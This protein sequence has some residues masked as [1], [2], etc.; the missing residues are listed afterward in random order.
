MD[1]HGL[2]FHQGVTNYGK[3]FPLNKKYSTSGN[4]IALRNDILL[5]VRAPV[6]RINIANTKMILGRGLCSIRSKSNHQTFLYEQLKRIFQ[7][8]DT[9]GSGT[10]FNSVTKKD[11]HE[12]KIVFPQKEIRNKF[13]AI[14][15]PILEQIKLIVI[16]N[17]IIK[18]IKRLILPKFLSGQIELNDFTINYLGN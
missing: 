13:E 12:I 4:R 1:G 3:I 2:P 8:E 7:K 9:M 15:S 16:Q 18:K 6:G 11:V 5:S 17:R 10:I 14:T